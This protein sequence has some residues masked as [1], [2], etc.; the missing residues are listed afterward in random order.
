VPDG[1]IWEERQDARPIREQVDLARE[2]AEELSSDEWDINV[3]V[4]LDYL[5]ICGFKLKRLVPRDFDA[6]G[7]SVVSSSDVFVAW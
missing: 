6:E 7:V 1:S 4:V 5:A 3:A 2:L